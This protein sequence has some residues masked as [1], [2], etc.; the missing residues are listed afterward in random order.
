M[1]KIFLML[2]MLLALSAS[3]Q[4]A[5]G[6]WIIH[7]SFVGNQVTN[8]AEG[9]QWVYYLSGSNLFRLDK[10]TQEN[11][12]MTIS[13]DLSDMGIADIYYNSDK[14]Y[15]VVVYANSNID[16][17]RSNG[18]VVNMPEIKNAMMTSSKAINDVTFA[19]GLMYLATDFGYVVIDDNK[20]VVKESHIYGERLSS[21]AQVGKWLLLSS[22]NAVYYGRTGKF[23]EQLESFNVSNLNDKNGKIRPINDEAFFNLT[24]WTFLCKI[25]P[26]GN[27][28]AGFE[29]NLLYQKRATVVQNTKGGFLLSIP[30]IEEAVKVNES[31]SELEIFDTSGEVCSANPAGDGTPWAVGAK[32][33][34]QLNSENYFF[35]NALSFAQPFWMAYNKDRDKL[36]VSSPTANAFFR[37][38]LPSYINTYDGVVWK[39]VTPEN[40]PSTGTYWIEFLPSDPDTYLIAGWTTGLHRVVNDKIAL[41]YN[42]TNSPMKVRGGV[43]HPITTID[44]NGNLWVVQTYENPSQPV[45]VLPAAKLKQTTVAASDWSLPIVDG[46][47]TGKSQRSIL[48]STKRGNHDIKLF[49][50]GDFQ[51]GV[52]AWNSNGDISGRPQQTFFN[53]FIDQDGQVF[54]WTYVMCMTED[55]NGVVWLG[56]TEGVIAF[57]PAQMFSGDFRVNPIKVPRNDGTGM[58]DY[59][60]SG[61]QV[62]DI[63]I[64]GANRK[65]IAT[66]TSGVFLVSADGTQIIKKFN[67]AN[68]PLATNTVYKVCCNPNNNSVYMTTPTGVYEYFSDSSPAEDSYSNI[69]AYPNPVRP[70]YGGNVTITGMMDNSLIK[71]ADAS[72]NVIRQLKSTGGMA[73][74]NCCDERG[75]RAKTGVYFVICSRANGGSE[76]VVTKIAVIR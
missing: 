42:E 28:E 26:R 7:T 52:T 8:I 49:T 64:D 68:S 5:V 51:S 56:C 46:L 17:I 44:R 12:A 27:D 32:G 65:W 1:K 60:M 38:A 21:V 29:S 9:N 62:N 61:I 10:T 53:S 66:Q 22:E 6:D 67:M 31:G 73:T 13:G 11:E 76:S 43:L 2:V 3:A 35:P 39:N 19:P 58:A 18:S 36:Y 69:Y 37:T 20:M 4:N 54:S 34:H 40:A 14:D 15:L 71:I 41:T 70:D 57:N 48:I 75:E 50:D 24:G 47:N 74:W 45:M 55:L 30:S 33:L 25:A 59:L 16:V 72:G 23:Y 63:A